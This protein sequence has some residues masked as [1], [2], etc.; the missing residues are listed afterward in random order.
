MLQQSLPHV[1]QVHAWSQTALRRRS[2]RGTSE[3]V[4]PEV[5]ITF[6]FVKAALA[7]VCGSATKAKAKV[8]KVGGPRLD[9][10]EARVMVRREGGVVD[11]RRARDNIRTEPL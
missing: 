8:G 9:E 10:R 6:E 7:W 4:A 5:C 11:V 2:G 3:E 1:A